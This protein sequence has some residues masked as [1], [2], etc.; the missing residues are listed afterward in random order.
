MK[1]KVAKI[2]PPRRPLIAQM[3]SSDVCVTPRHFTSLTQDYREKFEQLLTNLG[4]NSNDAED[5][6]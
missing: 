2:P 5:K 1:S 3:Y 6:V 4:V